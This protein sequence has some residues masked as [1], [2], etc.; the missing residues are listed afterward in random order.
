MHCIPLVAIGSL[1]RGGVGACLPSVKRF[2]HQRPPKHSRSRSLTNC[3]PRAIARNMIRCNAPGL[4]PRSQASSDED[5]R[6]YPS[7]RDM[8][9]TYDP[10]T[11]NERNNL[12][13]VPKSPRTRLMNV[14]V[15]KELHPILLTVERDTQATCFEA[16]SPINFDVLMCRCF[17]SASS[18][19]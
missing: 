2:L 15:R 6:I 11:Q 16:S 17:A 5:G 1:I 3:S 10:Q 14:V 12:S 9:P 18:R 7:I 4:P 13:N 19:S 8:K